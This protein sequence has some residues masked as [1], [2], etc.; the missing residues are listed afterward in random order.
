MARKK[1]YEYG[2]AVTLQKEPKKEGYTFSK[3]DHEDGFAM[4][5]HDV[6]IKEALKSTAIK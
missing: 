5:A 2:S 3:W 6:V 1:T 4:P